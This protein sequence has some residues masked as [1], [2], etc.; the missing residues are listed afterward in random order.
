MPI[1]H[2]IINNTY[3]VLRGEGQITGSEIVETNKR[4]Y[5]EPAYKKVARFQLW[6]L[7]ALTKVKMSAREQMEAAR[8][9]R[10][11]LSFYSHIYVA[12]AGT[13]DQVYGISRTYHGYAPDGVTTRAFRSR[14]EAEEWIKEQR[15]QITADVE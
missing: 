4:L 13:A 6:D 8:Q 11:A 5:T 2:S 12:I 9:D 1:Y 3:I 7:T 15:E 14:F 10:D